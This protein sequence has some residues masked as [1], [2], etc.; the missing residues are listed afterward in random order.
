MLLQKLTVTDFFGR[1]AVIKERFSKDYRHPELDGKLN[2]DRTMHVWSHHDGNVLTTL[3]EVRNL[4]RCRMAGIRVPLVYYIHKAKHSIWMEYI[5]V[6]SS[7]V[8]QC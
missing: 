8:Q 3:Q 7:L 6:I 1:P 5:G 2:K 4:V